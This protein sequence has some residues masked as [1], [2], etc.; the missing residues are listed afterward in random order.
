VHVDALSA[1][2]GHGR[3]DCVEDIALSDGVPFVFGEMMVFI[4]VDYGV[5]SLCKGYAAIRISTAEEPI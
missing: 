3:T 4:G 1:S 5:L 2:H